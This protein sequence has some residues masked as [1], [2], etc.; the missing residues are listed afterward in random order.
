MQRSQQKDLRRCRKKRKG[1]G[2]RKKRKLREKGNENGVWGEFEDGPPFFDDGGKFR[3]SKC[4]VSKMLRTRAIK[5]GSV[6]M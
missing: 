3:R 5:N 1:K 6:L 4:G 2:R